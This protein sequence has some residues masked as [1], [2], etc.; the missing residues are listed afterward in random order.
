[1]QIQITVDG[2]QFDT[3]ELA[4]EYINSQDPVAL[5]VSQFAEYLRAQGA[6]RLNKA[7][8][9]L[10][11]EYAQW[12]YEINVADAEAEDALNST[13][14]TSAATTLETTEVQEEQLSVPTAS[15]PVTKEPVSSVKEEIAPVTSSTSKHIDGPDENLDD[16]PLADLDDLL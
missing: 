15:A 13:T 9:L 4:Q 8:M 5:S 6:K 10:V 2:K 3:V 7:G 1:M 16:D 11:E 14:A 12:S